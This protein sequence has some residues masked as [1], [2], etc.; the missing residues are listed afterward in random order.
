MQQPW[1]KKGTNAQGIR[2]LS[3]KDVGHPPGRPLRPAE[4]LA[5]KGVAG[6]WLECIINQGSISITYGPKTSYNNGS[7]STSPLI[8]LFQ[9]SRKEKTPIGILKEWLPEL[10]EDV[11]PS[12]SQ[13][14]LQD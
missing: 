9:V 6:W 12:A 1:P 5:K 2:P 4:L 13:I 7:Y 14:P 3:K 11:D 10:D 8:V